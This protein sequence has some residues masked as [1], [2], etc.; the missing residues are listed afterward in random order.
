[1]AD[2]MRTV[3]HLIS[4]ACWLTVVGGTYRVFW[5]REDACIRTRRAEI[6]RVRAE[7]AERYGDDERRKF[8]N[9]AATTSDLDASE[10]AQEAK[11]WAIAV[12]TA[13][14][15]ALIL[16]FGF[17]AHPFVQGKPNYSEWP[18][19]PSEQYHP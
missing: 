10:H 17:G 7:E 6:D 15:L 19:D 3:A 4:T 16:Y 5:K 2:F 12:A 11:R 1:M 14:V 9:Q 18:D 8:H 13:F